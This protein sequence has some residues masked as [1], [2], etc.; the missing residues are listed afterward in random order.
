MSSMVLPGIWGPRCS[1]D[2]L[3]ASLK[4]QNPKP[5]ESKVSNYREMEEALAKTDF[6]NL[7]RTP[8]FEPNRGAAVPGYVTGVK[9]PLIYMPIRSGPEDEVCSWLAA[10]DDATPEDLPGQLNQKALRQWKRKTGLHRSFTVIR[11]PVARAHSAF[12][13]KILMQEDDAF[14]DIRKTLRNFHKLPIPG[15]EPDESY[16]RR[17]HRQA[18]VAFLEFLRANLSGQTGLRVDANWASQTSIIRGMAKFSVPDM[19]IREEEMSEHL[20]SLARQMVML[21]RQRFAWPR[22][23]NLYRCQKFTTRK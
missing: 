5:L 10:L 3:D 6:F 11:H 23:M 16:D 2:R 20:S 18:F 14:A 8:N 9:A 7:S 15:G 19:V 22:R 1:L 21:R 17:A 4:K 12:C 13:R